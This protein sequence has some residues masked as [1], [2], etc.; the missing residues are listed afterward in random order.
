MNEQIHITG[1]GPITFDIAFGGAFYA[2]VDSSQFSIQLDD[3]HYSQLIDY[4]K[5]IKDAIAHQ[6]DI[7]HPEE[8]DLSFYIWSDLYR[9]CS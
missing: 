5:K 1:I 2:I 7:I 8:N 9:P 3:S 4:G 6:Y